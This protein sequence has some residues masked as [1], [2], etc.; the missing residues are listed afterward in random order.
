LTGI[1]EFMSRKLGDNMKE[2]YSIKEVIELTEGEYQGG[3][4][5]SFFRK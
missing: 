1:K 4:F 5:A 3:K 2:K